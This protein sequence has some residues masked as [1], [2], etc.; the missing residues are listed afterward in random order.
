MSIYLNDH[1]VKFSEYPNGETV[2]PTLK[3]IL[4]ALGCSEFDDVFSVRL[5]WESDQD[6]T[7][8][9]LLRGLLAQNVNHQA[10]YPSLLIDYMPYSRMDREQDG[11]CFSLMHVA[12][13]IRDLDW[14]KIEVVEPHSEETLR[15]LRAQPVWAT[16]TLTPKA[17]ERIAFN[18]E[19]D[20][21]VLPDMGAYKRYVD[22]MPEILDKVNVVVL[23][24]ARDFATGEIT[25]LDVSY[26]LVRGHNKGTQGA[27][28]L[29]VDDLASRGGTFVAAAD[30][31]R[32]I[33]FSQ[34]H[35][36]VTHMEPAGLKGEMRNRLDRVFFTDT[37]TVPRPLP[38]NFECFNRNEWL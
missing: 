15:R 16:Q 11:S 34:V 4:P 27:R 26:T 9:T 25:G 33:G 31:L 1:L 18:P 20:F 32:S 17:M 22:L 23:K 37:M 3:D 38:E 35:L 7:R 8:L 21:I 6:L 24:K 10:R 19:H 13:Q 12:R 14:H 30:L 28:A 2:V 36:L 5:H 29:I